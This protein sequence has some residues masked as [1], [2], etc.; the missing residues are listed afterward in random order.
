MYLLVIQDSLQDSGPGIESFD[1]L[2][3]AKNYAKLVSLIYVS[4]YNHYRVSDRF[5]FTVF[6]QDCSGKF[7]QVEQTER[8]PAELEWK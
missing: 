6:Y 7:V 8:K 2:Q 4:E 1:T 5:I 3:A